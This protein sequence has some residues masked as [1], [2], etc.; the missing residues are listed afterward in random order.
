[1]RDK[2]MAHLFARAATMMAEEGYETGWLTKDVHVSIL[3]RLS[4]EIRTGEFTTEHI[5]EVKDAP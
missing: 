1:M 2:Q 4:H 5:P 3:R